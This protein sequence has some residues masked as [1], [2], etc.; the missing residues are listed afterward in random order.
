MKTKLL[1]FTV[2]LWGVQFST[3]G[4]N[5]QSVNNPPNYLWSDPN[6]W[7]QGLVPPDTV[8]VIIRNG[9][10]IVVSSNEVCNRLTLRGNNSTLVV[11][12]GVTLT[13]SDR[14]FVQS[15]DHNETQNI[16]NNGSIAVVGASTWRDRNFAN[17]TINVSG[18][19]LLSI[20]GNL[21][22]RADTSGNVV[23]F[24]HVGIF[25]NNFTIRTEGPSGEVSFKLMDSIS[26]NNN[27][28]LRNDSISDPTRNILDMR[29]SGAKLFIG[30]RINFTNEG[31]ILENSSAISTTVFYRDID[32]L[33]P[34]SRASFHDVSA[35]E[36]QAI[37]TSFSTDRVLGDLIIP[38]GV[39]L[40]PNNQRTITIS[41]GNL[42][43][44]GSINTSP[45][46]R[47]TLVFSG[48]SAQNITGTGTIDINYLTI[49]NSNGVTN[50]TPINVQRI[51]DHIGNLLKR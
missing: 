27:L 23:N 2:L 38:S 44:N 30:N 51:E 47:D 33:T 14:L 21:T 16:I 37:G 4:Q 36:T 32:R 18:T 48:S 6:S 11:N 45:N 41:S 28:V 39:A 50:S 17:Q 25:G 10:S 12:S 19:G 40:T 5:W 31:G 49:N 46:D 34:D 8:N 7:N 29:F 1:L 13:L 35:T 26:I 15:T 22:Y 42:I 24:D 43:V 20:G 3:I 9:D